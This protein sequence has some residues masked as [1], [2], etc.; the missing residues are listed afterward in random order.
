[1]KFDQILVI[2]SPEGW[3]KSSAW[4]VLAGPGNFSDA[5]ILGR[6]ARAVQE[7]LADVWIHEIADLS[8]LSRAEVEHVKAFASRTNDKARAAYDRHHK[9]QPRQSI[10]VGTTNSD[11]YLMSTTGNRRF[12]PFKM[13]A[14][15]ELARLRADRLQLW[16]EAAAAESVGETLVLAE[17][18]WGL[19]GDA[20]EARRA[21]DPWEDELGNLVPMSGPAPVGCE[22]IEDWN[23]EQF[24][25]NLSVNE[26][27]GGYRRQVLNSGSGRK[28]A[29]LMKRLGWE[30]CSRKVS[31]MTVR[32]YKRNSPSVTVTKSVT[33]NPF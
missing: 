19:A 27:L 20:Q 29:E 1:V 11:S 13:T 9:D 31:G 18:L 7:E 10:E 17:R 33:S 30:R 21:I 23:G 24:I 6:D 2:E 28:I 26:Y 3:D 14:R 22:R 8:G 16:G 12:W 25:S 32:G 5:P 15:V 4:E